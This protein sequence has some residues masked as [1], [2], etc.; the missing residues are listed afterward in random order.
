MLK[1]LRSVALLCVAST[2][3]AQAVKQVTVTLAANNLSVGQQTTA[4]AHTRLANGQVTTG[5]TASWGASNSAVASINSKGVVS[6][7]GAGTA[8][9]T[10]CVSGQCGSVILTV[11]GTTTTPPAVAT[12]SITLAS[13]TVAAGQTVQATAT[14]RDASGDVLTNRVASWTSVTPAI[15]TV[16]ATGLVT[17]LTAGTATI[18]ATVDTKTAD[19][20][21]TVTAPPPPPPNDTSKANAVLRFA[22]P[23]I[24]SA[25]VP[26]SIK[27]YETNFVTNSND[28]WAAY[29][30]LWSAG[31]SISGYER[32]AIYYIW[33]ARTGDTTYLS[34]AHETAVNYRDN[35]LIPAG[36]ATSPHWSQ[37][38]S[39]YLDCIVA[40]DQKSCDALPNV[41][42]KL[43]GFVDNGYFQIAQGEPR[44][45]ARVMIALWMNEKY[46]GQHSDLLDSAVVRSLRI[47]NADGWAPFQSTCGGSLNY[48]NGMLYD[49]LTRL[50]DQRPMPLYNTLIEQKAKAYGTYAWATQWRG[51]TGDLSFNYVSLVCDGTGSPTSAPDLNG[52]M[53][54]LFGWLGKQTGDSTWFTRGDLV[55]QGM[56]NASLYL[57]RQFSES[58]TSSY[59]YLGYRFAGSVI[60]KP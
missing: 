3:Y 39:M 55:L 21:I 58:Y 6:T 10:G 34:R 17:A 46:T 8:T 2:G 24:A 53:L 15:A 33:W 60:P 27:F 50:H 29:G 5:R 42:Y 14:A 51:A 30:P 4:T 23:T 20:T 56:Q 32:A 52:L 48:M 54:P 19:A 13:T 49:V 45:Q 41:A 38:E 59:R 1:L 35:Y 22:G 11:T 9:I 47:T 26:T 16:N 25:S 57:Y 28:Q 31:N 18:R 7:V 44:I 37:M 40:K 43:S 12:V 36:Y